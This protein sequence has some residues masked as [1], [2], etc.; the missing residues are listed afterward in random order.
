MKTDNGKNNRPDIEYHTCDKSFRIGDE[1]EYKGKLF[2]VI[3]VPSKSSI[4]FRSS[5][6]VIIADPALVNKTG[7][8]F[9]NWKA[10]S[11]AKHEN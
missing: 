11:E 9:T 2:L 3:D 7:R 6:S 8:N 4:A 5:M 1:V 10:W